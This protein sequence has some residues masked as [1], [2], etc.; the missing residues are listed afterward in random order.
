M[1][2]YAEALND[3]FHLSKER[4][5]RLIVLFGVISEEIETAFPGIDQDSSPHE[6]SGVPL[7]LLHCMKYQSL[8]VSD[9]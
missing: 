1:T 4:L 6:G 8:S 9:L 3:F 2:R 7:R 5:I